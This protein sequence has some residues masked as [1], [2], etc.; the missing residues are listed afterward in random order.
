MKD[1]SK[2]NCFYHKESLFRHNYEK[3]KSFI[4]SLLLIMCPFVKAL[5][6]N[7]RTAPQNQKEIIL[8]ELLEGKK[9]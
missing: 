8:P 1:Y 2:P 3:L 4:C 5:A 9:L 7:L 6:D